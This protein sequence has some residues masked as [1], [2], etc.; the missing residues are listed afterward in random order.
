MSLSYKHHQFRIGLETTIVTINGVERGGGKLG[1]ESEKRRKNKANNNVSQDVR[2]SGQAQPIPICFIYQTHNPLYRSKIS[3]G[4]TS[5]PYNSQGVYTGR[6]GGLTGAGGCFALRLYIR[7]KSYI[8]GRKQ[9][10]KKKAERM[11][12]GIRK[13]DAKKK[14]QDRRKWGYKRNWVRNTARAGEGEMQCCVYFSL[15]AP[16][17]FCC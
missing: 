3:S 14:K 1:N 6:Q 9:R 8:Q 15:L 10:Q 7:K 2:L 12:N 11:R 16:A 4:D 17:P 13:E 5:G